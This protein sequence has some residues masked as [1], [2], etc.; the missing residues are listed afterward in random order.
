MSNTSD[1]SQEDD[2]L[3]EREAAI[4]ARIKG[5][6]AGAKRLSNRASILRRSENTSPEQVEELENETS[7]VAWQRYEIIAEALG[8]Q[9]TPA[10]IAGWWRMAERMGASRPELGLSTL[11]KIVTCEIVPTA[12]FR[13]RLAG[14]KDLSQ[15][16]RRCGFSDPGRGGASQLRRQVGLEPR[17]PGGGRQQPTVALF[18]QYDQAVT[19]AE[20]LGIPP[21][22]AGV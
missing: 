6:L 15:V 22:Q 2:E 10:E 21:H 9:Y 19:L 12:P 3:C 13:E 1:V 16:A 8:G 18:M 7:Q 4:R 14:M 5:V 17:P 11:M 20:A